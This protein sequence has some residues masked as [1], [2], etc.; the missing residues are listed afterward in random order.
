MQS[1]QIPRIP[2]QMDLPSRSSAEPRA[3]QSNEAATPYGICE[4]T[5]SAVARVHGRSPIRQ[6]NRSLDVKLQRGGRIE[7]GRRMEGA[8]AGRYSSPRKVVG[9]LRRYKIE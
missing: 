1:L 9:A 5:L 7:R 3:E 4:F 8:A 2:S 6:A